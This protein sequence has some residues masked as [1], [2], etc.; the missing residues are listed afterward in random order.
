VLDLCAGAGGKTLQLAAAV[1]PGGRVHAVDPD[2]ERL[3]RLRARTA[4]AGATPWVEVHGELP[5]EGLVV[6]RALVD[7]PCSELGPL[8]RGPDLRWRLDPAT[9][10]A[11]PAL[12]GAL[13]ARAAGHVRPGGR[14]VYATCTFRREEDEDV[15]EAFEAAHPEF[16]RVPALP[17]GAVGPGAELAELVGPDRFLRT[18]PHRHGTDGFFAAAWVRAG[19]APGR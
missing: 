5:P 9:F 3:E 8:R 11:L 16:T 7:A 2:A 13:L 14:L 17:S 19:V 1:G 4:R 15:A 12:Q 10:A 6:D 18:W